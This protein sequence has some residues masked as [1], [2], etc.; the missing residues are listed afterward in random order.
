M[1][2]IQRDSPQGFV[3]FGLKNWK[4]GGCCAH[5]SLFNNC[6]KQNLNWYKTL[7]HLYEKKSR[8]M[9]G[10]KKEEAGPSHGGAPTWDSEEDDP[11]PPAA[12]AFVPGPLLS[13][14]DQIEKDKVIFILF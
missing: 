11:P 3:F 10:G 12:A 9:E 8:M 13:L 14:K 7:S 1:N 5:F 4:F 2:K 6:Q